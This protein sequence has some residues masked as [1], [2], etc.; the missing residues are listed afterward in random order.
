MAGLTSAPD[1]TPETIGN[2]GAGHVLGRYELL[3]PIASG[4]MAMVW[5]ARL[6]GTHGFQKIVAIKTMLPNLSEDEQFQKMF[7]DEARLASRIRH[8]H[9]VE[10]HDLGE[11]EGVLYLVMEWIDGVPLNQLM[12]LSKKEGGIPFP[13]AVRIVTQACAGLHA[14]HELRSDSGEL[15]GLVHR[16][17]SPQNILVTYEGVAKVVDFGVAKATAMGEGATRAGQ[18]KGKVGYMA[19]EQVRGDAIDRKVDVFALGILLYA[20]TTGKHPFRK[21]NEAATMFAIASP[22]PVIAPRRFMPDYPQKL[23]DVLL[24]ALEKDTEKRYQTAN[25]LLKALDRALPSDLRITDDE[26]AGFL[27][28][29]TGDRREEQKKALAQALERADQI[30][31][32]SAANEASMRQLME[33]APVFPA[34]GPVSQV[35]WAAATGLGR[36]PTASYVDGELSGAHLAAQLPPP[37]ALAW[38]RRAIFGLSGV[39]LLLVG[40]VVALAAVK[41]GGREPSAQAAPA[42]A[43]PAPSVPPAASE[44]APKP[45]ATVEVQDLEAVSLED[46]D[47][48]A[49]AGQPSA[50][51]SAKT[52]AA[53]KAASAPAKAP[54]AATPAPA[55]AQPKPAKT[56]NWKHSAGF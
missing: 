3:V 39:I 43:L 11:K 5:A 24:K 18:I 46:L 47:K 50:P 34:Q 20:V 33:Q 7:L 30:A 31:E 2:L 15:E 14:A 37:P 54:A 28:Q 48:Q 9:V 16:D 17:V 53:A 1:T 13:V 49:D 22:E 25:D 23:Q 26:V 44:A 56:E 32:T 10:I 41:T 29:V 51:K 45:Q 36:P 38:R 42:A 40:A 35:S 6:K 52:G 19:P 21:E 12:K 27:R 55:A 8:P 4:G